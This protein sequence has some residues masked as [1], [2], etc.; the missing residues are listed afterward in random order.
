MKDFSEIN[1]LQ[2]KIKEMKKELNRMNKKGMEAEVIAAQKKVIQDLTEQLE[3]LNGSRKDIVLTFVVANDETMEISKQKYKLA[4]VKN[5][6]PID[7]KKVDGFISI[8]GKGKYE[9]AYPIIAASAKEL[10][11]KGY[12]VI[13]ADGNEVT[14]ENADEYIVILDGQH[15]ALA[16]LDCNTISPIEVPNTHIR[17]VD[18][19]GEY[20]VDIN[21]VGSSWNMRDRF[22]VAALVSEDQLVRE[23]AHRINEGF[24]PT[25][26]ALIY[27]KKQITAKQINNLLRGE[28]M[29]LPEGA[30]VNIERGNKFILLCKEANMD[31]KFITRRYFIK[32][33]NSHALSV[34]DDTAFNDLRRLKDKDITAKTLRS[35]KDDQEFIKILT[36]S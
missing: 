36:A 9:N 20:L 14:E 1:H 29:K 32:A 3:Q 13:D 26:A 2:C 25:T 19:V 15:R 35:V 16:F 23:I 21:D 7:R 4:F 8:I 12:Q 30:E 17:E 10:I 31:M 22:T 11:N 34:G 6:R 18:N 27:T 28:N 5:N 33:F 24:S